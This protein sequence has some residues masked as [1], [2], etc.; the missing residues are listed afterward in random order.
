L[1]IFLFLLVFEEF[2]EYK[3]AF[4]APK[5]PKRTGTTPPKVDNARQPPKQP[6]KQ[7][8]KQSPALV[9]APSAA[10]QTKK[11]ELGDAKRTSPRIIEHKSDSGTARKKLF[12]GEDKKCSQSVFPF[13]YGFLS[14]SFQIRPRL[15]ENCPL[16]FLQ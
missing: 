10:A 4:S 2:E 6:A 16:R 5:T 14:I 7:P 12:A 1:F 8:A 15:L 13:V 3:A 11:G 9:P